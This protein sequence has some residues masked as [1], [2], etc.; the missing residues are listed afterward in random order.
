[1]TTQ[2]TMYLAHAHTKDE[3]I[4]TP[5]LSLHKPGLSKQWTLR[6]RG[7]FAQHCHS[8]CVSNNNHTAAC[9]RA[10][11]TTKLKASR[12]DNVWASVDAL[13][14]PMCAHW[15]AQKHRVGEAFAIMGRAPTVTKAVGT[16][17]LHTDSRVA[18]WYAAYHRLDG[19]HKYSYGSRRVMGGLPGMVPRISCRTSHPS[20]RTGVL[21]L[22]GLYAPK[23]PPTPTHTQP[24]RC[25]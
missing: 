14:S 16:R 18:L 7:S 3:V 6:T 10:L 2:C 19:G 15:C 24:N 20:K 25:L 12:G 22:L 13:L 1:M 5:P 23:N 17:P 8:C 21:A 11:R 9:L 4:V